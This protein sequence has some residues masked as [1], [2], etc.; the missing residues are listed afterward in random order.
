MK[1]KWCLPFIAWGLVPALFAADKDEGTVVEFGNLKSRTPAAWKA[2]KPQNQLRM[3]QFRLP[4]VD[5]DNRGATVVIFRNIGGSAAA[6]IDRWK[7]QFIPPEGKTLDDVAKVTTTKVSE[8]NV[9]YLDVHGTYKFKERPFD[10][11]AKEER[12]PHYRML[13]VV[14]DTKDAPYHIRLVG[15]ERTVAHYKKGFDEWLKGFK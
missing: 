13:A 4:K 14:F 1:L 9:T 8:A 10:P 2:E 7:K 3:A 15:P 5:G 12:L 11:N 6:N